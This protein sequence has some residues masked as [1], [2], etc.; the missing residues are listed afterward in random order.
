MAR[1]PG[2]AECV[3]ERLGAGCISQAV[4]PPILSQEFFVQLAIALSY[5]HHHQWLSR[6]SLHPW[7]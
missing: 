4:V 1:D 3:R 2:Q 7:S 5:S 6:A